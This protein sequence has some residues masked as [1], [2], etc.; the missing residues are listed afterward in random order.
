MTTDT[1]REKQVAAEEPDLS[2][3]E[4]LLAFRLRDQ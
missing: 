2:K 3:W 1:E 4:T